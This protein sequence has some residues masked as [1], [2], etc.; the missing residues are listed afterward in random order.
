[1]AVQDYSEF[2]DDADELTA[3]FGRLVTF[4][5]LSSGPTDP[6]KPWKGA[7]DPRAVPVST[8]NLFA[9]FV[10]PS[11]LDALGTQATG[12]D[13]LKRST[14]I[15][16]VSSTAALTNFDEILES[17]GSR[18]KI[19]GISTLEPGDTKILHYVGVRR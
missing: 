4:V 13:F 5:E 7:T 1:M 12:M 16:I 2:V 6:L 10:E 3:E 19:E 18:W 14:K 11:T 17:D 15:A 8:L 9:A